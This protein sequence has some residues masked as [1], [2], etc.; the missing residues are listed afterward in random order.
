MAKRARYLGPD[1]ECAVYDGEK[2]VYDPPVAVVKQGEWLPE[3]V[4]AR[5]R[6]DLLAL[7]SWGEVNVSPD[8][9]KS[10]EKD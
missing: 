10:E 5:I 8:K 4:P 9:P 1:P 2:G 7:D 3:D 6:D